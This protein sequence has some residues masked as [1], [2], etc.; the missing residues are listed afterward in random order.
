MVPL[1]VIAVGMFLVPLLAGAV[2]EAAGEGL[3]YD[4]NH[5]FAVAARHTLM[6]VA[7]GAALIVLTLRRV[8]GRSGL[9]LPKSSL[10]LR[11]EGWRAEVDTGLRWGVLVLIV[12]MATAWLVR[13]L[14]RLFMSEEAFQAQM[15]LETGEFGWL[16]AQGAP[17]W[18]LGLF[19]FVAV[20][21]A[22]VSEELF[23]RGYLHAVFRHRAPGHA[24]FLSSLVFAALHLY[25]IHFVPVFFIGLLLAALY[26]RRGSLIAPI[27]AHAFSNGV[28]ALVSLLQGWL[29]AG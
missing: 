20:V 7:Q 12:N 22:P 10:G 28:V 15:R 18:I 4:M 2:I 11:R 9:S 16:A 13:P 26:E 1:L 3:G 6:T 5:P 19:V 27:V 21:L 24:L 29:Q 25:I 8:T 23:F 14:Y 17:G